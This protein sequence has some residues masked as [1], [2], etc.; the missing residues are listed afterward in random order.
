MLNELEAGSSKQELGREKP[1]IY[2]E[3]FLVA[4][5]LSFQLRASNFELTGYA[6]AKTTSSA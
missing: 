6:G 2:L 3:S 1:A 4:F 5:S